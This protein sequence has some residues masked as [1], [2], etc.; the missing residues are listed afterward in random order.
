M[1]SSFENVA[2]EKLVAGSRSSVMTPAEQELQ[3][4]S[5]AAGNVG[6]ANPRVTREVV[7]RAAATMS[8]VAATMSEVA[9]RADL[10]DLDVHMRGI[11]G[12]PVQR[13]V[14]KART[15]A[16]QH[17]QVEVRVVCRNVVDGVRARIMLSGPSMQSVGKFDPKTDALELP[18]GSAVVVKLEVG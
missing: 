18:N 12:D 8:E 17:G 6:L 3:R 7:D 16:Q 5:F 15:V 9:A 4:R 2:L 1:K 13:E 11:A 14:A 10:A